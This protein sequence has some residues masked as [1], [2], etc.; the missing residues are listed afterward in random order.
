MVRH[1]SDLHAGRSQKIGFG[2]VR[3]TSTAS[4]CAQAALLREGT[5]RFGETGAPGNII[6]LYR[7]QRN[8]G[9]VLVETACICRRMTQRLRRPGVLSADDASLISC[10]ITDLK[11]DG[12]HAR[13]GS[14]ANGDCKLDR[15]CGGKGAS[16]STPASERQW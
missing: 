11:V 12:L 1:W 14:I 8:A 6:G 10:D 7:T 13:H 3:R 2:S 15:C 16:T 4:R 5:D 9:L